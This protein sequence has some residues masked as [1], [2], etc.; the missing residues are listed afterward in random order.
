[1]YLYKTQKARKNLRF[2]FTYLKEAFLCFQFAYLGQSY[3]PKVRVAIDKK[4]Y[5]KIIPFQLRNKLDDKLY[6]G[7]LTVLGIYRV[8]PWW[9][10]VDLSTIVAPHSGVFTTLPSELL[11][12]AKKNLLNISP[13]RYIK[14]SPIKGLMLLSSGPNGSVSMFSIVEDALAF[15]YNKGYFWSLVKWY[16]GQGGLVY[17]FLLTL[18]MVM[19]YPYL[20]INKFAKTFHLGKLSTVHD[21]AGKTR[22]IAI[23][24]WWIQI[25]L[26]PVHKGVFDFLKGLET[27]GTFNQHAPIW[28]MMDDVYSDKFYSFDLSAATDRLPIDLQEQVLS[29][30]LGDKV[31]SSWRKLISLPFDYKGV[32]IN[33]AVGQPMGAYSSWAVMAL[34]HHMIVQAS[35]AT[36]H[37]GYAI[38]GDDVVINGTAV[39]ETYKTIMKGLGVEISIQKTLI[40]DRYIEFAKKI[41]DTTN[42]VEI[43]CLGPKLILT[44][45][46]HKSFAYMLVIESLN[47]GF[48][49]T[50]TEA[51][52]KLH[53]FKIDIGFGLWS[54]S[55]IVGTNKS[56]PKGH[57]N[58]NEVQWLETLPMVF[59]ATHRYVLY[60]A[61][62]ALYLTQSRRATALAKETYAVLSWRDFINP[63]NR[64]RLPIQ[65]IFYLPI[66]YVSP[67]FWISLAKLSKLV[68][69]KPIL[70]GDGSWEHISAIK[71]GLKGI[72]YF[73]LT[74]TS[75]ELRELDKLYK[76]FIKEVNLGYSDLRNLQ[77]DFY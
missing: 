66:A 14:L 41:F 77:D 64:V 8:I 11:L 42:K 58:F 7:I 60:N 71:V 2:V 17:A 67:G 31:S 35:T 63:D 40:S 37:K 22:V 50:V 76:S 3:T 74:P 65:G 10:K 6:T 23:T 57:I 48:I 70:K 32:T 52:R 68:Q 73:N 45:V 62:C 1:M 20:V 54:I 25:A 56:L 53:Q 26:Y 13:N 75:N 55:K 44:T 47:R 24:N 9:P 69:P 30:F 4:G 16:A 29:S 27:D 21:V 72:D 46:R 19:G 28:R 15:W 59:T 36:P 38:L 5:P 51:A 49:K 18:M 39:A 12:K 33:Y 43:S 61:I 34:T